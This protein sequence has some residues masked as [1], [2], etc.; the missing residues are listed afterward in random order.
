MRFLQPA[1]TK[2][3]RP[4]NHPTLIGFSSPLLMSAVLNKAGTVC[5]SNKSRNA[6][7]LARESSIATVS[8]WPI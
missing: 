4:L 3:A 8:A 1:R 5:R 2:L 6:Y 7:H